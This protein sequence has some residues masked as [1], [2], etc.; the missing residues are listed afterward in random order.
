MLQ[1]FWP[2]F[3]KELSHV[4][5]RSSD[6]GIVLVEFLAVVKNEVD[7]NDESLK[8]QILIIGKFFPNGGE[9]HGLLDD[10]PVPG[11]SLGVHWV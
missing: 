2:S 7:I 1:Q 4:V 9:V 10:F 8:V 3:L 5:P 6:F 11:Y